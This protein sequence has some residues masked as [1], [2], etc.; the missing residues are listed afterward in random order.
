ML[1]SGC[2]PGCQ[3]LRT[4]CLPVKARFPQGYV[5][6]RVE[7]KGLTL[8][9]LSKCLYTF[10]GRPKLRIWASTL[11]GLFTSVLHRS[12]LPRGKAAAD[13][14]SVSKTQ[15]SS[16]LMVGIHI[17]TKESDSSIRSQIELYI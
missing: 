12:H 10:R 5:M 17:L 15:K 8:H 9:Y 1:I 14:C 16:G 13:S 11:V 4:R 7:D 6:Q 3:M 2:G